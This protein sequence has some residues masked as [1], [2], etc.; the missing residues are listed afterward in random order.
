[1]ISETQTIKTEMESVNAKVSRS[2]ALLAN[3]SLERGRW[4]FESSNFGTPP[5]FVSCAATLWKKE[6]IQADRQEGGKV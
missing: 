1:M 3:L 2:T 6:G 5:P 4:E